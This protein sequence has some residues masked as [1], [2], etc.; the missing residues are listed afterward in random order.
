MFDVGIIGLTCNE[1]Y[2]STAVDK[3]LNEY[4]FFSC[5]VFL[6][7]HA[8]GCFFWKQNY[9]SNYSSEVRIKIAIYLY[10]WILDGTRKIFHR[11]F[12][13]WHRLLGSRSK[14]CVHTYVRVLLKNVFRKILNFRYSYFM[15]KTIAK[16]KFK[17]AVSTRSEKCDKLQDGNS[18]ICWLLAI[19]L[20]NCS[21]LYWRLVVCWNHEH[22]DLL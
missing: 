18:V 15:S 10:G 6:L 13:Q 2:G 17:V 19:L 12:L 20:D 1:T 22:Q 5:S 21:L 3:S 16:K 11:N 9:R 8:E 7:A 14:R 4:L